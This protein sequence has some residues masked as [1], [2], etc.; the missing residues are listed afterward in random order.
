[1]ALDRA[2]QR[3]ASRLV[4][5]AF[6]VAL[7]LAL[8]V[9]RWL[10]DRP[11]QPR[12][13]TTA[14]PTSVP[15]RPLA[16]RDVFA[17]RSPA[18]TGASSHSGW[19]VRGRIESTLG[20]ALAGAS[21]C[22]F[23]AGERCCSPSACTIADPAG[24][25]TLHARSQPEGL[26]ASARGFVSAR[27]GLDGREQGQQ[28]QPAEVVLELAAAS[29]AP[30]TGRVIDAGGGTV[31]SAL[32]VA[33]GR[34]GEGPALGT[35]LSD[36][37]GG[38]ELYVSPGLTALWASADG[39]SH[40]REAVEAPVDGVELVMLPASSLAGRV[41]ARDSGEPIAGARVTASNVNGAFAPETHSESDQEG[42]FQLAALAAGRHVLRASAPGWQ[43]ERVWTSLGVAEAAG[44]VELRLS[45]A[46][47]LRA[48][49][50]VA[51]TP[52]PG[53]SVLLQGLA[54]FSGLADA[55]GTLELNDLAPGEYRAEVMCNGAVSLS[56]R[57]LIDVGSQSVRHW[58]LERGRAVF[59]V[60]QRANGEPLPS[61]RVEVV[62]AESP[63][64]AGTATPTG[65]S[66]VT[67]SA[68]EAGAFRC[69]GLAP[70][71]YDVRLAHEGQARAAQRVHVAADAD[72]RVVIVAQAGATLRVQLTGP[73][74][75]RGTRVLARHGEDGA[76]LVGAEEGGA[77]IFPELRLGQY[78]V[79]LASAREE[80]A[81]VEL[82]RDGE[83][84][85][86]RLEAPA[87]HRIGGRVV[88]EQGGGLPDV[89]VRATSPDDPSGA[90]A[91]AAVLSDAQGAFTLEDLFA[92]EYAL[93]A[94]GA[95]GEARVPR[96]FGGTLD[97]VL[98]LPVFGRLAGS[99]RASDGTAIPSFAV[100]Y[101][102]ESGEGG[103]V[104]GR[105]GAWSLDWLAPGRY[106][107]EIESSAGS[108][109]SSAVVPAAGAA[110][111]AFVVGRSGSAEP[112][113]EPEP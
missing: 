77:F 1:M 64:H 111:L 82:A 73:H 30:I 92:G 31:E 4:R 108:A 98:R 90:P 89:W 69:E 39:Y 97:V 37:A 100:R 109:R 35:T 33:H 84:L 50:R 13:G 105:G 102:H 7:L 104:M 21:V 94:T 60:V 28:Q 51:G 15:D 12:S 74:A 86:L 56:E 62:P 113:G 99:V 16:A 34:G 47:S 87:R 8:W 14:V 53:A 55:T 88:D 26:L 67:C 2:A 44:E 76:L 27:H 103:R 54:L 6:V 68:D 95:Q 19:L 96:V 25:F 32:V 78:R 18:R 66:A 40:A 110:E 85:D 83:V 65:G 38:F 70:G 91:T 106:V 49:I 23:D 36:E 11:S 43:D 93:S 45:R 57:L 61:A 41:L 79:Y 71:A 24:H 75:A 10:L 101:V 9:V 3:V 29:V 17:G 72:A 107:I 81:L 112:V 80:G 52:C 42:R 59:G 46:A 58:E 48:T 22:L 5:G 63:E 20:V